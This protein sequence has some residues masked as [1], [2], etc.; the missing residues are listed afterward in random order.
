MVYIPPS[1]DAVNFSLKSIFIPPCNAV[2]F[3]LTG[4]GTIQLGITTLNSYL[5]VFNTT[6]LFTNAS[7]IRTDDSY[8]TFFSD[9]MPFE[10]MTEVVTDN[11]TVHITSDVAL[12]RILPDIITHDSVIH[13][14]SDYM[15]VKSGSIQ[16][17]PSKLS[18]GGIVIPYSV[19]PS[20]C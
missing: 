6:F 16:D 1:C 11:S 4:G 2:D 14:S 18:N 3:D 20:V 7:V 13:M 12:L 9:V 17:L 15:E 10:V 8:L 5:N 19:Y